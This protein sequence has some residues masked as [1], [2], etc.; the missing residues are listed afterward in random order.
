MDE[1]FF[2][3]PVMAIIMVTAIPITAIKL[4]HR[5]RIEK[6]RLA[7]GTRDTGRTEQQ[8]TRIEAL[9]DRLRV[10][11]RIVTDG[12]YELASSIEA[13]RDDR[14]LPTRAARLEERL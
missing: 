3:I 1:L 2:L 12:S 13:L 9:E 5:E 7:A 4:R 6:M 10:L 14:P 11:E 8:D